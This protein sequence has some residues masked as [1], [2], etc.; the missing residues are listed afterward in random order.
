MEDV[1]VIGGGISGLS[2]A[3][4][5]ARADLGVLVLEKQANAG[6]CIHTWRQSDGF[7]TELG[8]HTCYNSYTAMLEM[9]E[10]R[11]EMGALLP[12]AKVPFRLLVGDQVRSILSELHFFELLASAPRFFFS[13]KTG[14]SVRAFYAPVVGRRNYERVFGPLF[15]AVPSQPADDFPAE[16][17]FKAR[18]RRKGVRRSFTLRGGL[19][20]LIDALA[21]TPKV[22][23]A[24]GCEVVSLERAGELWQAHLANGAGE[25]ARYLCLAV[26]PSTGATLLGQVNPR[27][28][29][30][31]GRV[32]VTAISTL[33]VTVRR[34]ATPLPPV[35]GIIPLDGRFYS[36]VS[37]DTVPD[38]RHRGFA[39]HAPGGTSTEQLLAQAAALLR[40]ERAGFEHV[41]NFESVLP[42]PRAG[43]SQIVRAIDDAVSGSPLFIT[44]NYFA[45]LA[46]EDCVLRSQSES[47]RL[48]LS[49]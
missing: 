35:A 46:I 34:D 22:R 24:T 13:R 32:A 31:L 1:I 14:K 45:G 26:P 16:M 6:G 27:A 25:K 23:L 41:T 7:W 3:H 11:G 4:A 10:E 42:A 39:F 30:A 12:R 37:R 36:A 49:L 15:R 28:A 44:G 2:F 8:A 20:T 18:A 33:G 43:H 5:C 29:A 48:L 9:L 40:V 19:S 21:A 17:L 38:Q 47:H